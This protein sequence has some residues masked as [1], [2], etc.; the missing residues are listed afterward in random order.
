LTK[1]DDET[2]NAE[3]KSFLDSL[4]LSE[5]EINKLIDSNSKLT[6]NIINLANKTEENTQKMSEKASDDLM[7]DD[8]LREEIYGKDSKIE[9][10]YR[11]GVV[12]L[13]GED[14]IKESKRMSDKDID[15]DKREF[16][17]KN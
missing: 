13:M 7:K 15:W 6:E 3:V 5:N 10:K 16:E 4:G 11:S 17:Y 12:S 2:H 8:S 1:K 9:E 14:V